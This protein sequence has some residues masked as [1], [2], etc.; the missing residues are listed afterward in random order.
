MALYRYKKI[1]NEYQEK[2]QYLV[3]DDEDNSLN[4][5]KASAE[6][7]AGLQDVV[8]S[9]RVAQILVPMAF[10]LVGTFFI[11]KYIYPEIKADIE[12]NNGLVAQGSTSLVPD[13]FIDKSQYISNPSGLGK[14]AEEAFE[15]NILQADEQSL[16]Y[17]KTFY[18]TIPALGIDRLP[19]KPNVDS[20]TEDSYNQVL[21]SSLAHFKNTGLPIS[22]IQQNIV[23]YGH[24]ASPNYN[25]SK[26]DPE[27]AFSFIPNLKVGDE[28]HID[29]DGERYTFRM[30]K[31]KIVE[32]EDVSIIT[33]NKNQR[34]L[35][36]FTCYPIGNN[37]Q[38]YV[39]VARPV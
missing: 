35:T 4:I 32:P 28:I 2:N 10:I 14:T 23:I 18:I 37:S 38:R 17:T 3:I 25:P 7:Y 24:S 29:M 8:N 12:R 19:V 33:G 6:S 27:V 16:S 1:E 20:T 34:T 9:S 21:H 22:D 26:S 39:A 36:L 15:T 31:S 13:D 30:F 5:W 11:Y